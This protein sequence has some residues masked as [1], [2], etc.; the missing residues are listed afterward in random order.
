MDYAILILL[1]PFFSFLLLGVFGKWF[2]HKAAGLVGTVVLGVVAVMAY[3]TAFEYFFQTPRTAEG[4]LPTLMPYNFTW[5]PFFV[6]GLSF[7]MGIM[8]DPISVM[9]LIVITTVSL[10]VHI[11]SIGYMH[12]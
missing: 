5:L 7:N 8:L 2:S 1:L 6:K 9:M 3:Y 10:K 4:V 12:S 11:Y